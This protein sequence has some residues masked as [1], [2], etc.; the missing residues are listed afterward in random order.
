MNESAPWKPQYHGCECA[1]RGVLGG[2]HAFDCPSLR[3]ADVHAEEVRL[4]RKVNRLSGAIEWAE[5]W[6][7]NA[8]FRASVG[9]GDFL[10]FAKELRERANW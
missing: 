6:A 9:D 3:L 1:N 7:M 5:R 8:D 10:K 2:A 4:L